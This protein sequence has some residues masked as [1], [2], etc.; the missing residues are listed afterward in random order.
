L[1]DNSNTAQQVYDA[2][3]KKS[4]FNV[5]YLENMITGHISAW[6][7]VVDIRRALL[8]TSSVPKRN[9]MNNCFP[10]DF[11]RP[12]NIRHVLSTFI[13]PMEQFTTWE[14][15]I[16]LRVATVHEPTNYDIS[17][18]LIFIESAK[19]PERMIPFVYNHSYLEYRPSDNGTT[20]VHEFV[21]EAVGWKF[22]ITSSLTLTQLVKPGR[23]WDSHKLD[24]S[25]IQSIINGFHDDLDNP[26]YKI[27]G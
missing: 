17:F 1:N 26:T 21:N 5:S 3:I 25:Y 10:V 11:F 24:P 12:S 14:T 19:D 8:N 18:D 4:G 22:Q 9:L 23:G 16:G 2:A 7:H 27:I 13:V 20:I 6:T 15:S